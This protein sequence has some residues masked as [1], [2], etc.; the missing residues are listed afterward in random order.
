LPWQGSQKDAAIVEGGPLYDEQMMGMM[1]SLIK[2]L[3]GAAVL[4]LSGGLA[5]VSNSPYICVPG[6]FV[7]VLFAAMSAH[8]FSLV[9]KCCHELDASSYTELWALTVSPETAWIPTV[10]C[11]CFTATLCQIYCVIVRDMLVRLLNYTTPSSS[12]P[13]PLQPHYPLLPPPPQPLL[14]PCS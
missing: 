3:L 11:M 4:T 7:L 1:L 2:S 6:V 10:A 9:G 13:A 14:S 5:S 12:S 8:T